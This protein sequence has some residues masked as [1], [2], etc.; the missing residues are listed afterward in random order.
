MSANAPSNN[1]KLIISSAVGSLSSALSTVA[2]NGNNNQSSATNSNNNSNTTS[3]TTNGTNNSLI[4][5]SST[6]FVGL[7]NQ[8]CTC[9]LNSLIQSLYHTPEFRKIIFNWRYNPEKDVKKENCIPYQL[10]KLFSYLNLSKRKAVPTNGLTTSFGWNRSDSF[11]QHDVQELN[12]ILF[13]AIDKAIHQNNQRQSNND[14]E[15]NILDFSNFNNLMVSDLYSGKMIDYIHAKNE[16][17]DNGEPY[18]RNREDIY[19]DIQLVIRDVNSVEEALTN[20]IK[21]EIM[22]NDNQWNCEELNKK[23]DA[24]KGLKFKT[25]PYILTLHLKRFDYDY[26]TWTRIKLGNRV[27][28]PF[29]LDMSPY[30]D[31][32]SNS[33]E[34]ELF[35]VLIHSG[36]ALGGHYYCYIK[37]LGSGKWF[38]FNDSNVS[39]IDEKEVE[40]MYGATEPTTG[41]YASS[42][43]AYMLLYRRIDNNLNIN[44]VE[45]DMIPDE[46]KEEIE[47]DNKL[48]EEE[49][50][51]IEDAKKMLSLRIKADNQ[52]ILN[53][54][55]LREDNMQTV[56]EKI[57]TEFSK[58][59]NFYFGLKN[60]RLRNYDLM[61]QVPTNSF[62]RFLD[63]RVDSFN[64]FSGKLFYLETKE[65]DEEW[66][67]IKE[68]VSVYI[69]P[70][71]SESL[72]FE[73]PK[74]LKLATDMTLT[75]IKKEILK[76]YN[77]EM[78]DK[79]NNVNIIILRNEQMITFDNEKEAD[80]SIENGLD[81]LSTDLLY[82]E[83]ISLDELKT[84]GSKLFTKLE[85]MKYCFDVYVDSFEKRGEYVNYISCDK[86]KKVKDLKEKI[87][88]LFKVDVDSFRLCER[89][90]YQPLKEDLLITEC[91]SIY[92]NAQ[93]HVEDG[94]S[95]KEGEYLIQLFIHLPNHLT[96]NSNQSN[97]DIVVSESSVV[98][99]VPPSPTVDQATTTTTNGKEESKEVNNVANTNGD[100]NIP[101]PPSSTCTAIV[102]VQQEGPVLNVN[103]PLF[104]KMKKMKDNFKQIDKLVVNQTDKLIDLKQKIFDK[105]SQEY[106]IPNIESMRLRLKTGIFLQK[107]LIHNDKTLKENVP[108]LTH[109]KQL[110][111][112]IL[113]KPEQLNENDIIVSV[114]RWLPNEWKFKGGVDKKYEVVIKKEPNQ[115]IDIKKL[116]EIIY[117]ELKEDCFDDVTI[118]RI[119]NMGIAKAPSQFEYFEIKECVQIGVMDYEETESIKDIFKPP[120][121][122]K[123]DDAL[124]VKMKDDSEKYDLQ[125]LRNKYKS[126]TSS[127]TSG[128]TN[129]VEKALTIQVLDKETEQKLEEEKKKK[130]EEEKNKQQQNVNGT[131]DA[132][133]N[134]GTTNNT[135]SPPEQALKQ[136]ENPKKKLKTEET[137]TA[138]TN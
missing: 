124:I 119:E 138:A 84:K 62:Q 50:K 71:N 26:T 67:E 72:E 82:F 3:T 110:T 77:D 135:A 100:A 27:T 48:I 103:I 41:R 107:V 1:D 37:S 2:A 74:A 32:K 123:F 114:Q 122:L 7:S 99:T 101:A 95:L 16:K 24:I 70:F 54:N 40:K 31:N 118:D 39:E 56:L 69:C 88:K 57:H 131:E 47:Q 80:K 116:K 38:N 55:V 12:R 111:V 60:C 98:A 87:A 113:N 66:K 36:S 92:E 65:N 5:Q 42:T 126:V 22:D 73:Q 45:V 104:E 134:N 117:N 52:P 13:D 96:N 11:V 34:Y 133:T 121:I 105:F 76:D 136:E 68:V 137:N 49:I 85:E 28:F 130:E 63:R 51:R 108:E 43:N 83:F 91:S 19:M 53:I 115:A 58:R 75:D 112:Q 64:F 4:H 109:N 44:N 33:L 23:V 10:Q 129:R 59:E 93:L 81:I 35:G 89:L 127:A 132:A 94:P 8:G 78:K 120:F 9:Y 106:N 18:G 6:G 29:Q 15:D 90:T 30:C 61:K 125:E 17:R 97:N 14:N 21:P 25:L 128:Y 46:L 20:F 102:P 86:R 79:Y